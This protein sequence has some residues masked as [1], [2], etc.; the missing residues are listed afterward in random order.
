MS[1]RFVFPA[2]SRRS[3]VFPSALVWGALCLTG[4]AGCSTSVTDGV[5]CQADIQCPERQICVQ[6]TCVTECF[7][8]DECPSGE[9]R[10]NVCVPGEADAAPGDGGALDAGTDAAPMVDMGADAAPMVD[11]GPMPD[12]ADAG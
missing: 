9:C 7:V 6:R 10:F 5:R 11:M 2:H 12:A 4:L 3:L 1:R 8:D